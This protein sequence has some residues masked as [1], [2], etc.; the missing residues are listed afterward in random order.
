[1]AARSERHCGALLSGSS[2]EGLV[3]PR[4]STAPQERCPGLRKL[5]RVPRGQGEPVE[6]RVAGRS[7]NQDGGYVKCGTT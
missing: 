1:M 5:R 3:P 7:P 6:W 4:A 2:R